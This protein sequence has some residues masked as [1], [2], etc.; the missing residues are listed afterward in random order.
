MIVLYLVAIVAANLL[1]ARFGTVAVIPNA[2]VLIAFDLA[3]RDTLHERWQGKSLRLK[4]LALIGC[5]AIIS[6]L[7]NHS[8]LRIALASFTAFALA[9]AVDFLIYAMFYEERRIVKANAS[10]IGGAIVDSVVFAAIAFGFPLMWWVV[11]GQIAAKI[12]GGFVWS[13]VLFR[14]QR[15]SLAYL[16]STVEGQGTHG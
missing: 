1:V 16:V 6:A 15:V 5:G 3:A 14:K 10:N 2:L 9:G 4:M 12:G 11:L 13:V 7:L 8:A